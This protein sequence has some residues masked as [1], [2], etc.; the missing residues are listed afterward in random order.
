MPNTRPGISFNKEGICSG[1]INYENKN[2]TNWDSR[3]KELKTLCDKYRGK[4]GDNH[5][6]IIA[7]SGGKD[8]HYQVHVMKELME[9]NPLLVSV[10][11]NFPMTEAGQHN[12]KNISEEFGC[13]IISLKP[14]IKAQKN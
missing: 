2:K 1:C 8:S 7:V 3:F 12:I 9:M 11:D 4:Y 14:N 5:D 6:C 13:D 10:E